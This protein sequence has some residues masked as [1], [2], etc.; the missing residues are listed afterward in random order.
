LKALNNF[1]AEYSHFKMEG[2]HML[3]NLL[4]KDDYIIKLDLR[5]AYFTVPVWVN[6]KNI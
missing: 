4:R 5:D 1:V 6:H 3:K 2:I